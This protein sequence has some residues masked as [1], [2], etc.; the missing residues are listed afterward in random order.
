MGCLARYYS[1]NVISSKESVS[2]IIQKV[3]YQMSILSLPINRVWQ[4][5]LPTVIRYME[6][7]YIDQFFET[8]N[9]RLGSFRQFA[10]HEDEMRRDEGEGMAGMQLNYA[11]GQ[12]LAVA[13]WFGS[14]AY[15][16]S[17]SIIE[18]PELMK[19]FK[20]DGYFRIKD[21]AAFGAAIS[22][23]IPGYMIGYEGS[24]LYRSERMI[25]ETFTNSLISEPPSNEVA[26]EEW[27]NK[28]EQRI[29]EDSQLTPY[30]LKPLS[31]AEQ[32]EYR[33][34]WQTRQKSE[35]YID[36]TC[37]EAIRFCEKVT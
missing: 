4:V 10:K 34:I 6:Q 15:V 20:T 19:K 14:E 9:L 26:A 3:N 28:I 27:A 24:C 16:L 21:T 2:Q 18:D 23:H 37:P 13:G 1:I 35:D 32:N 31:Y 17:T 5:K 12:T 30:F 11:E 7:Q 36:V 22:N 29:H 25:T 8:G 33:F